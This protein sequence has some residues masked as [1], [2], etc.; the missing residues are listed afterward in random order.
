MMPGAA[1]RGG[2]VV[3]GL[4]AA[5]VLLAAAPLFLSSYPLTLLTQALIYA[6]F[7]MSLDILLGYTGLPKMA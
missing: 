1:R 6:I 5:A 2:W 3:A 7:A 4:G